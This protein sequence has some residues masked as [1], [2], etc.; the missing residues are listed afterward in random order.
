VMTARGL[1]DYPRT[2]RAKILRE[3]AR[4]TG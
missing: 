3:L 2:L 4:P 1:A